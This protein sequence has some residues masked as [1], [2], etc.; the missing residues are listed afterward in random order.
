MQD[1]KVEDEMT[2]GEKEIKPDD[3]PIE[4][5]EEKIDHILGFSVENID[6][7]ESNYLKSLVIQER[8][9]R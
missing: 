8:S 4:L 3:K 7:K 5:K 1:M 9:H 2:P 6:V